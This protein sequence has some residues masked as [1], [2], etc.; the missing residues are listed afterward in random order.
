MSQNDE[1]KPPSRLRQIA[2]R[3]I[4]FII[5]LIVILVVWYYY[6][7]NTNPIIFATP[8]LVLKSMIT[9]F[10]KENFTNALLGM[11]WLLFLGLGLSVLIGIPTG[12]AMGRVRIVDEVLDPYMTAFYVVPRVAMVPL[13]II[14]FGFDIGTDVLFVYTFSFFPIVLTVRQGVINTDR[15]FVDVARVGVASERQIFTKV[16]IPS[17]LP[18]IFAG[19]RIALALAYIGVVISQLDLVITGVGKFLDT[20]Q[21]FYNTAEILAILI[22][23]AVIGFI[24]SELIKFIE[25]RLTKGLS[26]STIGGI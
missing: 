1:E 25:K 22:V 19:V 7:I 13:F 24:L 11:L 17:S 14:W 8:Q 5:S 15:L 18:Y 12:L 4:I 20:A 2:R 23:L 21:E 10:F 6:A 26:Y 3:A 16:I 9:I